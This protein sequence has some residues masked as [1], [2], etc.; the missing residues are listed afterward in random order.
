[1]RRRGPRLSREQALAVPERNYQVRKA[2]YG[3]RGVPD[4]VRDLI[5][6]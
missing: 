5:P 1:M 3:Q 6:N 2:W 4:V